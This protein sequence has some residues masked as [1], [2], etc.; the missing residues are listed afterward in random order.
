MFLKV[1]NH[2]AVKTNLLGPDSSKLPTGQ[3]PAVE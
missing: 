3:T 2:M 1:M